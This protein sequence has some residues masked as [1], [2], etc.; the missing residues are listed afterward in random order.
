MKITVDTKEDSHEDIRRVVALLSSLVSKGIEKQK[1]I[2]EDSSPGLDVFD[3]KSP[4]QEEPSQ[5]TESDVG[6]A[7]TN[8]FGDDSSSKSEEKKEEENQDV[9][10]IPY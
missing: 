5:A 2:F 9:E 10:L 3:Q 1:N 7:F 6:N 4:S 8:L